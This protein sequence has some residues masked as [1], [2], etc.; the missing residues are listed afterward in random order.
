MVDVDDLQNKASDLFKKVL[1]VG[2]GAAFLTEESLRGL[3]GEFK[4]PKEL[5]ASIIES[6]AKTRNDFLKGLTDEV[7]ARVVEKVDPQAFVQELLNNNELTFQ[8]KVQLK[9]KTSKAATSDLSTQS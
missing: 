9:P 5:I 7:I 6:A 4:L 3:V 2:V 1:T 8:V